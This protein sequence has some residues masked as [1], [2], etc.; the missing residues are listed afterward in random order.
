MPQK[1]GKLE[2]IA[3]K[4]ISELIIF[5]EMFQEISDDFQTDYETVRN[6]IPAYLDMV[7]KIIHDKHW[8]HLL[9][10]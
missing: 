5:L 8:N 2:P 9:Y 7:N 6:V 4:I 3:I 1:H 10:L